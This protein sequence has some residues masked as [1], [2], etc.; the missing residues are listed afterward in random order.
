MIKKQG[1]GFITR[2]NPLCGDECIS[3]VI[4]EEYP[5]LE[6]KIK[7]IAK[8]MAKRYADRIFN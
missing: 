7:R 4:K 2:E 3:S 6:E 5:E 8:S 1:V